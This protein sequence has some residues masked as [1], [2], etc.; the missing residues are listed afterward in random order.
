[1]FKLTQ[2]LYFL[3]A[4]TIPSI[5]ILAP[6]LDLSIFCFKFFT[7]GNKVIIRFHQIIPSIVVTSWKLLYIFCCLYFVT[8]HLNTTNGNALF[9][10]CFLRKS[11]TVVH[12]LSSPRSNVPFLLSLVLWLYL[13]PLSLLVPGKSW[14]PAVC[15]CVK[16]LAPC[17]KLVLLR[18]A[19][20]S[21]CCANVI[22]VRSL[23]GLKV[24]S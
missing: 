20:P 3:C 17:C 18:S 9:V 24:Y 2:K 21:A 19:T 4:S 5:M 6:C 22:L 11:R 1:M 23:P 8:L 16:G 15:S 7:A 13:L 12:I 10:F 14:P